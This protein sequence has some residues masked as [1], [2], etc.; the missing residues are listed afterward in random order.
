M[1][2]FVGALIAA[3]AR[4]SAH[5]WSGCAALAQPVAAAVSRFVAS[6]STLATGFPSLASSRA[7]LLVESVDPTPVTAPTALPASLCTAARASTPASARAVA[8]RVHSSQCSSTSLRS[9]DRRGRDAHSCNL[10]P[11]QRTSSAS[12]A[13]LRANSHI[14]LA[15]VC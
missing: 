9:L 5:A 7:A 12:G 13:C 1:S 11:P 3:V 15:P 8:H 2:R 6:V 14:C 10:L 4:C